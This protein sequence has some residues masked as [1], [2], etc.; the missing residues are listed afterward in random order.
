MELKV[1]WGPRFGVCH[2]Y[3]NPFNGIERAEDARFTHRPSRGSGIHSMELK[4]FN[5]LTVSSIITG[6][7]EFIQWN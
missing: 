4:V 2:V 3:A 1:D 5:L 6:Y 7:Y